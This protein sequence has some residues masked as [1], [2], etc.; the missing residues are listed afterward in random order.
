M[1]TYKGQTIPPIFYVPKVFRGLFTRI[2]FTT[3]TVHFIGGS[4]GGVPGARPP[5]GSKILSFG[6]TKFSKRNRLGSQRPPYEVHAPPTGNP[7]PPLHLLFYPPQVLVS[8]YPWY[9]EHQRV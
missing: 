2:T 9:S 8:V 6:H 5:Q 1:L 3:L 4:T 7:D